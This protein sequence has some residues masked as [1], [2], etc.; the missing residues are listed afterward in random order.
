MRA[1]YAGCNL[2]G[3]VLGS[4]SI[5]LEKFGDYGDGVQ[6]VLAIGHSVVVCRGIKGGV[7]LRGHGLEPK[8]TH[9]VTELEFRRHVVD[10]SASDTRL[11][12]LDADGDLHVLDFL[13]REVQLRVKPRFVEVGDRAVRIS[14]GFGINVAL[15]IAGHVYNIPNKMRFSNKELVDVKTGNEHCLL[16]D[17]TG[18]VFS[19][20]NG[21]RGQLGHGTLDAEEEPRLVD[22]LAGLQ[23]MQIAAGSWHSCA[24]TADGVLY[25]WGW[26]SDGQLGLPGSVVIAV[27]TMMHKPDNVAFVAAGSRHTIISTSDKIVY[28][29]GC[30]KF[31]QLGMSERRI[32]HDPREVHYLAGSR[33]LGGVRCGPASSMLLINE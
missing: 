8:R 26:N 1:L 33:R 13:D 15:T 10:A 12:F 31:N 17:K 16:L 9:I 29:F 18:N 11:V 27:P 21:S 30:N 20:G 25:V 3:Q 22:F 19:F 14:C 4:R 7:T 23:V 24:L 28:G 2:F 5:A 6:D 32:F